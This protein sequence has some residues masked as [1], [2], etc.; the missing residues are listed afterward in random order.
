WSHRLHDAIAAYANQLLANMSDHLE[1]LRHVLQHLRNVLSQLL[2]RPATVPAVA[3]GRRIRAHFARKIRR[4]RPSGGTRHNGVAPRLAPRAVAGA[5]CFELAQSELQLLDLSVQLFRRASILLAPQLANQQLQMLDLR[6]TRE[7]LLVFRKQ[8]LLV[9][10]DF[11]LLRA[12]QRFQ[13][14]GIEV[15]EIGKVRA[16]GHCGRSMPSRSFSRKS[17]VAKSLLHS[18][19]RFVGAHRPPTIDSFQQHRQLRVRQRNR[20]T[21][22]LWPNESPAFQSLREKAKSIT[23][24]PQHLDQITAATTK[25]EHMTRKGIFLQRSLHHPAQAR[26]SSPQIRHSSGNPDAR[27]CWQPDHQTRLSITV[28]SAITSTVPKTRSVPFGSLISMVP[29]CGMQPLP[30]TPSPRCSLAT[31]TG[32][33]LVVVPNRPS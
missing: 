8:R 30:F 19:L 5:T 23:I 2:H 11:R 10:K 24:P 25:H 1:V 29:G 31:L 15:F 20:S 16:L 33:K 3:L 18:Q 6:I 26:E 12:N 21:R 7:K 32:R 13:C 9:V 27:S 28:R 17:F 4:Q 14:F 22:R